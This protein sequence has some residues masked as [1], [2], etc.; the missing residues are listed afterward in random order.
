METLI[1]DIRYGVRGVL[2][3]PA[4]AAVVILTL[5]IGIGATTTIFSVVNT[6]L[7]RRLPY[8]N[9]QRVVAIEE[10]GADG[11]H[12]QVTPANFLDWRAQSTVFEQLAA[13]FTR[14][15]NLSLSD[16]AERIDIAVTSANFF[17]VLGT[18]ALH[19]RLFIPD[20]E[21]AGHAAVAV[22]SHNLWQRRFGSDPQFV[23]KTVTLDGKAYTVIGVAPPGFQ[24]PDKTEAWLPPLKLVPELN[25]TM[26]VT[27][28]RGLGFLSAVGLLK[29]GVSVAQ[30]ASEMETVTARLRQQ[31][32]DTN[33]T[34][35]DRVVSLHKHLVGETSTMLWLLF[36]AVG[37][38]LLIACANVANLLL[39]RSASRQKEM[40]IREA[41]GA[42][43]WRVVR[44]V[45]TESTMLG[46]CGG[47]LGLFV[48]WWSVALIARLLP[49][50]F[51]RVNDISV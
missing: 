25:A 14:P 6:V 15:A 3:R 24:Y 20:D 2:K 13:I 33:N 18:Q 1:K 17:S 32:P 11:K 8:P 29:P 40:A 21:Y 22:I 27:R 41:L 38:V 48:A 49:Q 47:A 51:P 46:L 23:G 19:G 12:S 50:D 5:A 34:R 45:L 44:Q 4:F 37:F 30:A 26:D 31:Y 16:Q 43:R 9:A 39:A 36:G 10:F 7:L 35:F 28:V 42:S